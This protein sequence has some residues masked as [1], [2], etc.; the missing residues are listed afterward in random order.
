[1]LLGRKQQTNKIRLYQNTNSNNNCISLCRSLTENENEINNTI[2]NVQTC[3]I[4]GYQ[5]PTQSHYP[6]TELA[7][8]CPILLMLSARL[9][10]DKYQFFLNHWFDTETKLPISLTRGLRFTD[11]ATAPGRKTPTANRTS[12]V[13]AC[14]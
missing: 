6:D 1:M 5:Y 12:Q 8:P 7:S 14:F 11:S 2:Y 13:R 3:D 9:G 4:V 10:S